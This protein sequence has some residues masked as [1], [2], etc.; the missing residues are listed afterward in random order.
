MSYEL[1]NENTYVTENQEN[2][3]ETSPVA[4]DSN[5]TNTT[6]SVSQEEAAEIS[7]FLKDGNNNLMISYIVMVLR[8]IFEMGQLLIR[9]FPSGLNH[10]DVQLLSFL[11]GIPFQR[12]SFAISL[13]NKFNQADFEQIISSKAISYQLLKQSL[14]FEADFVKLI[15]SSSQSKA[16]A[17]Q[18]IR[19]LN[20]VNKTQT[21]VEKSRKRKEKN[22]KNVSAS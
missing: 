18:K 6:T 7:S 14:V 2:N 21:P 19:H 11:S 3:S 8:F 22:K 9:K 12:I 17:K 16:E 13:A 15:F 1:K 5:S 20:S 10:K 4:D